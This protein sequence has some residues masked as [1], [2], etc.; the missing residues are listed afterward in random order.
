M[1][2]MHIKQ[3]VPTKL[4]IIDIKSSNSKCLLCGDEFRQYDCETCCKSVGS[5]EQLWLHQRYVHEQMKDA[6]C[7]IFAKLFPNFSN[8]KRHVIEIHHE[9]ENFNTFVEHLNS[10][11]ISV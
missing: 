9:K 1:M 4:E 6:R 7:Q 10:K 8:A 3:E 2:E 11:E 5:E